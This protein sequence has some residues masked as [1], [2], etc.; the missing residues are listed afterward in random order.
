[1][2]STPAT[3]VWFAALVTALV[4]VGA[5][6]YEPIGPGAIVASVRDRDGRPIGGANVVARGPASRHATT[7]R[8]GIVTLGALPLGTYRVRVVASGFAARE[9]SVVIVPSH[10]FASIDVRLDRSA[11]TGGAGALDGVPQ[12]VVATGEDP[13]TLRALVAS[14]DL[15]VTPRARAFVL[16]SFR[17][18]GAAPY[19]SR[20]TLDGIPLGGPAGGAL[21]G[22]FDSLALERIDVFAGSDATAPAIDGAIAGVVDFRS[23]PLGRES[24]ANV[25]A[26]H[27]SAFGS[28]QVAH[29]AQSAGKLD[30]A[31]DLVTGDG[32]DRA[33]VA[34]TR[35]SFSSVTSLSLASYGEQSAATFGGTTTAALA[36]AFAAAISTNVAGATLVARTYGS[37]FEGI[38][39][40]PLSSTVFATDR[41]RGTTFDLARP[42]GQNS[43]GLTYDRRGER[44]G[45]PGGAATMQL[46]TLTLHADVRVGPSGRLELAGAQSSGTGL[47]SRRDLRGALVVPAGGGWT[48]RASAGSAFATEPYELLATAPPAGR[49]LAPETSFGF[50]AGADLN[51]DAETALSFGAFRQ[52]RWNAFAPFEGARTQGLDAGFSRA[53]AGAGLTFDARLALVGES[54]FGGP[55]PPARY[56]GDFVT[57]DGAL[58][59]AMSRGHAAIGYRNGAGA[60]LRFETDYFGR[61][62][63]VA[64][65]ATTFSALSLRLPIAGS[66]AARFDAATPLG[67]LRRS[68]GFAL[69]E[70]SGRQ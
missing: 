6:A 19:E 55:Q 47:H 9:T 66:L 31:V 8:A 36:P 32:F 62:N 48:L 50:R 56:A 63:V 34:K 14:P 70:R 22:R 37:T 26:G 23:H 64:G 10:G 68:F 1:M 25:A 3:L 57:L 20:V 27:D 4:P 7:T 29:A 2:K 49:V 69:V 60:E 38:V 40:A 17:F 39:L 51:L 24:A 65:G 41:I 53:P 46:A 59:G 18:N 67:A 42:F 12:A 15:V 28:F 35:Y 30:A 43:F 16:S 21:A 58:S 44:I 52:A 13:V 61:N 54:A 33:Q 5:R 11:G 45:N